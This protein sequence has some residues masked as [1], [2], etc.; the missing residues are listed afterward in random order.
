MAKKVK[1]AT[2]LDLARQQPDAKDM[3]GPVSWGDKL[4]ASDPQLHSQLLETVDAFWRGELSGQFP[5][6]TSIA[7]WLFERLPGA[8]SVG[9]MV[10]FINERKQ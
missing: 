4:K 3:R 8:A 6:P 9:T 7:R 5:T 10:R 1:A 2:L